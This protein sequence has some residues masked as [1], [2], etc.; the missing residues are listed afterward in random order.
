MHTFKRLYFDKIF[1]IN[2]FISILPLSFII[3]NLAINLNIFIICIIGF[4][5]FK[6]N[7]FITKPLLINITIYIF[8]SFLI[9]TT[10]IN[11]FSFQEFKLND[12]QELIKS[13]IYCRFLFIYLVFFKLVESDNFNFKLFF[14]SSSICVLVI[15]FDLVYQ[16]IF[17][18]NILGYEIINNRPSSFFKNEL[19]AGG[20]IQKFSFFLIYSIFFLNFFKKK[21]LVILINVILL[22]IFILISN[23]RMPLI[24]YTAS[25]ILIILINKNFKLLAFIAIIL[26]LLFASAYKNN[27]RI[28]NSYSSIYYKAVEIIKYSPDLFL[29][30]KIDVQLKASEYLFLFNTGIQVWKEKKFLGHG[31]KSFRKKC[32]FNATQICSTHPHNYF[33]EIL[34]ETGLV[35]MLLIYTIFFMALKKSLPLILNKIN[36]K[37]TPFFITVLFEAFPIRSS[38]SFFTT[39]NAVIIFIFLGV[40]CSYSY[41]E[42]KNQSYKKYNN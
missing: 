24:I 40:L 19:I 31:I 23:N 39:N 5:I 7:I 28:Q 30:D 17:G 34:V 25:V 21:N 38:G 22:F 26:T 16:V 29:N 27:L 10:F 12:H 6:K 11:N 35:G 20:Y 4:L 37:L 33:I 32:T 36:F 15:G 14:F 8:F 41:K 3:G 1:L 42:L 9:I 13:I 18:K 2:C